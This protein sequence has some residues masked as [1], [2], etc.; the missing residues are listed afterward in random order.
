MGQMV[1]HNTGQT[2]GSIRDIFLPGRMVVVLWFGDDSLQ[3]VH[4]V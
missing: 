2:K 4:R 3:L 1:Q